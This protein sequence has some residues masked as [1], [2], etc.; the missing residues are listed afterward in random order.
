MIQ[1]NEITFNRAQL[2][3]WEEAR[4]FA[5]KLSAGPIVVGGGVKPELTDANAS[6]IFIPTWLSGPGAFPEPHDVDPKTGAKYFFLHYRF[7][8]GAEG[9]NVGL[10][11]D[12]F[13]RYPT[14]PS[15]V[16]R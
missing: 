11:M 4:E 15:Y 5:T 8:N 13:K 10:V 14:S 9:M 7:R 6:G 12:K 1:T 2:A 3:T 16:L